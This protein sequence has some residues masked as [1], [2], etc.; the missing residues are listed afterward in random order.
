MG[1]IGSTNKAPNT[2]PV[3][4]NNQ[5]PKQ[6]NSGATDSEITSYYKSNYNID[7]GGSW[8][9]NG[10]DGEI[11]VETSKQLDRLRADLGQDIFNEMGI[12]LVSYDRMNPLAFGET[13]LV[14]GKIT[15]N[16]KVFADKQKADKH[17]K[18]NSS[19]HPKNT[20]IGSVIPHELGHNLEFLMNKR[21]YP[22]DRFSQLVADANQTFSKTVVQAAYADIKAT[23]PKMFT[24][25]KQARRSISGYADSKWHNTVAYTEC[26]AEAVSDYAKNGKN[27]AP[28]SVAIWNN[29]VN[30]LK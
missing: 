6:L 15:V 17:Y 27:A 20:D 21:T 16:G 24:S 19:F 25:E 30:I 13:S 5:A 11:L 23:H 7:I 28:M 12:R 26:M 3:A 10:G 14:S 4:Q 9:K 22:N 29:I 2:Q 1:S 8:F 18:S